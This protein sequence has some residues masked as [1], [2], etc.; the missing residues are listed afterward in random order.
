MA[1]VAP[2]FLGV[3]DGD[4]TLAGMAVIQTIDDYRA[5]NHADLTAVAQIIAC[6]LAAVDSISLLMGGDISLSVILRLRGNAAA[7]GSTANERLTGT[8]SSPPRQPDPGL[9]LP[10]LP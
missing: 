5:P 3:T 9:P 2:I 4:L 7:D 1:L 6:G 8:G 10:A